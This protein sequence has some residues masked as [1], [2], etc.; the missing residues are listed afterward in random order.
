MAMT[1]QQRVS[2]IHRLP[3]RNQQGCQNVR[4]ELSKFRRDHKKVLAVVREI[5]VR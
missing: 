4:Q 5:P 2:N 1:V 3:A